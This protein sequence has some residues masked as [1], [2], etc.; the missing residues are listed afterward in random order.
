MEDFIEKQIFHLN[1]CSDKIKDAKLVFKINS[2]F[3]IICMDASHNFASTII[4]EM[5][6]YLK[7]EKK[8]KVDRV[9]LFTS[10]SSN[11][12]EDPKIVNF[13]SSTYLRVYEK[14]GEIIAVLF[15][16]G[17]IVRK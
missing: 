10:L 2:P 13:D 12:K 16:D 14:D 15:L 9:F 7:R 11:F 17:E 3:S 1:D 5:K 6:D 8:I 4:E